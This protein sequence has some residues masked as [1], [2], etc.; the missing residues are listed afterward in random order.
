[1]EVAGCSGRVSDEMGKLRVVVDPTINFSCRRLFDMAS[2]H[3]LDWIC[4]LIQTKRLLSVGV[5][6]P[7]TTFQLCSRAP[8]F[9]PWPSLAGAL[10]S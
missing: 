3:V 7:C 1:M 4:W 5:E 9:A 8:S 2:D 6:P 10:A